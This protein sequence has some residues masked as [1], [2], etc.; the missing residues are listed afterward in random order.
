MKFT[1]D[2][3]E[4]VIGFLYCVVFCVLMFLLIVFM[5]CFNQQ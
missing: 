1:P 3:K 4:T 5:S 2:E